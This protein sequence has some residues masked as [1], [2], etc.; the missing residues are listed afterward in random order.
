MYDNDDEFGIDA[1]RE[2]VSHIFEINAIEVVR[3]KRTKGEDN[4]TDGDFMGMSSSSEVYEYAGEITVN[5]TSR[6]LRQRNHTS[7]GEDISGVRLLEGIT[8]YDTELNN[9]DK[10][11]F[12]KDI[13]AKQ[14]KSGESFIV[15]LDDVG[16]LKGQFCFKQFKAYSIADVQNINDEI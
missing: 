6:N 5:V 11:V 12:I 7:A 4:A 10:I 1:F 16:S 13:E 2:D 3:H 9:G 8:E 14:I 15:K